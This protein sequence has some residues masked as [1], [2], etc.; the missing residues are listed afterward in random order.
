MAILLDS[1]SDISGLNS[2]WDKV[3]AEAKR[4]PKNVK[5]IAA[6]VKSMKKPEAAAETN[7]TSVATPVSDTQ[8]PQ[9]MSMNTKI[10]IGL[11]GVG[12]VTL[13]GILIMK[14]RK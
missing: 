4:A 11:A 8:E 7:Q 2:L 14:L 10:G 5:K 13:A 1:R 3:V 9:G 6:K 12:V